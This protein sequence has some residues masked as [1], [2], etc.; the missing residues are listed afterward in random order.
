MCIRDR[1]SGETSRVRALVVKTN[2]ELAI[3]RQTVTV[4]ALLA[5]PAEVP[6]IPIAVSARHLHLDADTFAR[7]FGEGATP[8]RY[9]D[10]SQPGQFACEEKVNLI[11]P[12]GRIDG[13]RLLGPLRPKTQVEVSRTDEFKLGIDAPIR[14]SGQVAGS[15]PIVLE[16]PK[17]TVSIAEGLICA[18]RHVHMHTDDAARFGVKDGDEIEVAITGGPRDIVFGDVLV[19][20]SPRYKLEMHIDTDEANAAEL[21]S[22]RGGDLVYTGVDMAKGEVREK[23][24]MT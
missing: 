15:A 2:E 21:D 10:I 18:K 16:G 22:G 11:G 19:R 6:V 20:V 1:I 13:V 8:T 23:R 12:R 9:K 4:L 7:L 5:P 14:D 3:A 17:G 24:V